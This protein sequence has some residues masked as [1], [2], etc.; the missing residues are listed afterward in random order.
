[1]LPGSLRD[2]HREYGRYYDIYRALY[3]A[4][5]AQFGAV[6]NAVLPPT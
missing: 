4:L 1:M 5:K 6:S 3:P 2:A